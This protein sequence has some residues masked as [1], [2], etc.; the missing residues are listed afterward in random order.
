MFI[1]YAFLADS[2][3]L[4]AA[5]KLSAI[6]IFDNILAT[7]FPT[8]HRDMVL[9]ANFESSIAERGEHIISV[10]LRDSDGNR[11]TTLEQKIDFKNPTSSQ[12]NLRAGLILRLQD[13]MF[14]R[15]GH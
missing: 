9:V 1:R 15:S 7:Q 8:R 6:G 12:E 10:E 11:L 2:I 5:G 3:T 14:P 13:L 4:D